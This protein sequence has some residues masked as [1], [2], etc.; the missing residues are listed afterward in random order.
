MTTDD[1]T[2]G[3]D[4]LSF[5]IRSFRVGK[6][7]KKA[8]TGQVTLVTP[9][10]ESIRRHRDKVRTILKNHR[11]SQLGTVLKRLNSR[12]RD[13]ADHFRFGNSSQCFSREDW[14]LFQQLLHFLSRRHGG[15][16]SKGWIYRHYWM[17][18]DGRLRL[19]DPRTGITLLSH[20]DSHVLCH[21][22]VRGT[23]SPFDGNRDYWKKRRKRTDHTRESGKEDSSFPKGTPTPDGKAHGADPDRLKG[24]TG[25]AQFKQ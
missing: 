6:K 10:K 22:K 20:A 1:N 25:S 13:W 12:I 16:K 18:I 3:F 5:N 14:V 15:K 23:A 4:F 2:P 17:R 11:C 7:R 19:H 8:G 9:S 21:I 24:A